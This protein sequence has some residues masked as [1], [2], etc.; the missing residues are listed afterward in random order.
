MRIF[1]IIYLDYQQCNI[2]TESMDNNRKK[3]G[4]VIKDQEQG[5]FKAP[6]RGQ[7]CGHEKP[8]DFLWFS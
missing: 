7:V 8:K 4:Q 2:F 3:G 5:F 1:D 6:L